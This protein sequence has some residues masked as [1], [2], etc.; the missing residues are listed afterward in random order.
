MAVKFPRKRRIKEKKYPEGDDK[1]IFE[2]GYYGHLDTDEITFL[3]KELHKRRGL[4]EKWFFKK[5]AQRF[6]EFHIRHVAMYGV[7]HDNKCGCDGT[8]QSLK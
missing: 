2:P 4:R 7:V 3:K 8:L 1:R 5:D 6:S